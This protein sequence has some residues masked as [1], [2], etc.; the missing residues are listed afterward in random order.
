MLL[1]ELN[2]PNVIEG[3]PGIPPEK[4]RTCCFFWFAS[5]GLFI[6][7]PVEFNGGR[8]GGQDE[9]VPLLTESTFYV[10]V[11]ISA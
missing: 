1:A 8:C 10:C 6:P 9:S 5:R 2:Q 3:D 7:L 4:M 11:P